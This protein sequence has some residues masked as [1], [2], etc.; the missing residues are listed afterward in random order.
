M[1]Q[2]STFSKTR[3]AVWCASFCIAML[4]PS[5][6]G[7]QITA[8][9]FGTNITCFGANNGSASATVISGVAPYTYAWSNGGTTA[10]I[11]NLGPGHYTVTITGANQASTSTSV[12]ITQPS[13]LGVTLLNQTQICVVAPN[14]TASAVPFGGVAPYTYAWSNGG[15]TAQISNLT[16]GT[17]TVTVTDSRGCTTATSTFVDFFNE[18]VWVGDMITPIPCFGAN[19]GM[20][21]AMPMTGTAPFT[22]LWNTGATTMKIQNLG[23]GTYTVTV[24]DANGCF[25]V[26]TVNLTQP[27]ALATVT[28]STGA[29]C[30][31][32]GT[33]TITPSGGTPPYTV[34]WSTGSNQFTITGLAPGTYSATVTDANGCAKAASVVVT[35]TNIGLNLNTSINV[36]AGCNIGGSATVAVLNGSG[37]YVY[38]WDNGNTGPVATNLTAGN[39]TVTVTDQVTGCTGIGAVNIPQASPI[40]TTVVLTTNATCNL[41]GSASASSTGGIAPYTY[42]WSNGQSGPVAT[43]LVAGTYTVTATDATGCIKVASITITQATGPTISASVISNATCLTGG[44]AVVTVTSGGLAPFTYLWSNGQ[45]TATATNLTPGVRTVTVT[46]ANGCASVASVNIGQSGVP[47]A[48]VTLTLPSTCLVGATATA[49]GAG[50]QAPYTY[51]WSNGATTAVVTNLPPATYTVT[52]RDANG[53]TATAGITISTPFFPSVVITSS[54]NANCNTPG[55]AT[56]SA[57]GGQPP[58]TYKWSNNQTT[59]TAVNLQPGVY[60]VTATGAN[61]CTA[62]TSVTIGQTNNGVT[63]GDFVW[64]D[65]DQNGVQGALE[66]GVPNVTVMLMAPGPDGFFNTSDDVM[67]A[68][69]TTNASGNYTFS[70]VVPG[71][72]ILKF[73]N[74]P[75]GYQWTTPNAVTNDCTDSDVGTNGQTGS[76]QIVA[77]QGNDF[78]FDGGIHT[79]CENVIYPGEIC[80]NQEICEGA[81]PSQLFPIANPSGGTGALEFMWMHFVPN[82]QGNY[83]WVGIPN[84]NTP[85]YQPG[86]LTRTTSYMRCVRR[87]NC[88]TFFETNVVTVTVKPAGSP[89]CYAIAADLAVN[90]VGPGSVQVT[91]TTPAE[92]EQMMYTV[93]HSTNNVDW[94]NVVDVMGHNDPTLNSYTA[95]DE[96]PVA[97]M[98]FYRIKRTMMTGAET[99]SIARSIELNLPNN[100]GVLI[101]PNPMEN[102]LTIKNLSK[103]EG[104]VE[105]SIMAANGTQVRNILIPAGTLQF[106]QETIETLPAGAYFARIRFADGTVKVVKLTKV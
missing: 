85:T 66:T 40:I 84:S 22:Y 86:P 46:D 42:Q 88:T 36:P 29:T 34:Q 101:Y 91:W 37:N 14:G 74:I 13:Q 33:A 89:G 21:T 76:F 6:A 92:L 78:C 49:V 52:V 32:N 73:T 12:L 11:N 106:K 69:T 27:T 19:N 96:S 7:A 98:N 2:N 10:A 102:H 56:A 57:A 77:G 30:L 93:Q 26:H 83:V 50:G 97:G 75:G 62:T 53:C 8:T 67:I 38:L 45:T 35:G 65:N 90:P 103:Y 43:N 3:L 54:S 15:N 87:V 5:L 51:T 105:I 68:S 61:G 28:S 59:A 72:Y 99:H 58:Y 47:T 18:G 95:M 44:S 63:I 82:A 64:Y 100:G 71:R 16:S 48:Q 17:Y 24:T 4:F 9:V 104:D 20:I 60:T 1:G 80:C 31:N 25:G 81:I 23:P 41:G 55:T 94:R 39:H 79:V 70:C